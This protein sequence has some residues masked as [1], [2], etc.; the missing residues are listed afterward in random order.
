MLKL[1]SSKKNSINSKIRDG[2]K[3]KTYSR[4]FQSYKANTETMKKKYRRTLKE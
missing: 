3:S 1:K 4:C 2:E